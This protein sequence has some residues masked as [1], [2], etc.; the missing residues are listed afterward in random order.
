MRTPQIL[1][2]GTGPGRPAR[3]RTVNTLPLLLT[4]KAWHLAPHP[5]SPW[6]PAFTLS[7]ALSL[8]EGIGL[9]LDYI[10]TGA[11]GE[12]RLPEPRPPSPAD[13]LWRHTCFEAFLSGADSGAYR[14]FNFSPSGQWASYRFVARRTPASA[15]EPSPAIPR[16]VWSGDPG[17]LR[18]HARLPVS[19]LPPGTT[20]RLG[21]SAVLEH[22]DGRLS[23]WALAH[24]GARPDFHDPA[25]WRHLDA[26]PPYRAPSSPP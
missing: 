26:P 10:L 13:E 20:W 25:G 24:P 2:R 14:E 9:G 12:L 19:V 16:L 5:A 8:D 7:V 17:R 15:P 11:L 23:H 18:L 6:Q 1:T 22:H 3:I 21:L 4:P